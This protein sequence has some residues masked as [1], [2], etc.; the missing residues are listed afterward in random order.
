V[1]ALPGAFGPAQLSEEEQGSFFQAALERSLVAEAKAGTI[2][3]HFSLAGYVIC[4]RF[5]GEALAQCFTPALAHLAVPATG[6][7]DA[8]FHIWDSQSTGIEMIPPPCP[9]GCFTS[10]GDIWT[11]GSQ[12]FRS[13]YLWSEYAL[14]LFDSVS[15]TGVYWTQ[16]SSPLPYWAKAS[17][18]RCLLHWWAETRSCQLL[19][20][21]AVG[22][23]GAAVLITG[24]GG[25]GKSTTALA[26]L[27]KGMHYLGD[28]YVLVRLDPVASVHSL[29]CTAKLN[30]DQATRFPRFAGL[31]AGPDMAGTEKAV[32]YLHPAMRERITES[33]PLRLVVTPRIA[34]LPQT[35]T[36]AIS[37]L[38]L[39]QAA[40]FTTLAQLPR[41]SGRTHD[42]IDRLVD[43]LP[44]LQ[45]AL[46]Q[47]LDGI[48]EAIIRLLEGPA[49]QTAPK[50]VNTGWIARPLVSVIIP[51]RNAAP[52]LQDTLA[53]VLAQKYPAI[54]IIVV[55]DGS[56]DE[57]GAAV[58]ALPVEVRFLK[59]AHRGSGRGTQSRNSR[60]FGRP[61]NLPRRGQPLARGQPARHDR[62]DGERPELRHRPGRRPADGP[63]R[64]PGSYRA[65]P[66]PQRIP[67]SRSCR[68]PLPARRIRKDRPLRPDIVIGRR[69]RLVQSR[70][71]P[72]VETPAIGACDA[73]DTPRGP[74]PGQRSIPAGGKRASGA[75]GCPEPA[76]QCRSPPDRLAPSRIAPCSLAAHRSTRG[77]QQLAHEQRLVDGGI[78]IMHAAK[79]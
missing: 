56:N 22:S 51:A 34:G 2:E 32:L 44:G 68:C 57:I 73:A 37:G 31:I 75:Q 28:D 26:C 19:H 58:R 52:R 35:E 9:H 30:W 11:M 50:A 6:R 21:A 20:A 40:A 18:L 72:G 47:D 61:H 55:D 48:A 67:V 29:Y 17:P 39:Q 70:P 27:D 62:P 4:L 46:G 41:A 15:A 53:S 38:A 43:R 10:R 63:G 13:A 49:R 33:L 66:K 54:E 16:G 14:N 7:P 65:W 5:A 1:I 45:L 59:Q 8:V 24:K 12:R 60:M 78:R 69:Q 36:E 23:G 3:R 25:L 74:D 64:E 77:T 76:A 71:G 42:F 79:K